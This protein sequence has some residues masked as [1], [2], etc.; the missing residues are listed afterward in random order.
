MCCQKITLQLTSIPAYWS[1]I[2]GCDCHTESWPSEQCIITTSAD[3]I[4]VNFS[5]IAGFPHLR[6]VF[7]KGIKESRKTTNLMSSAELG[8]EVS[9]GKLSSGSSS[10]PLSVSMS[11]A[12][13]LKEV[14]LRSSSTSTSEFSSH[15]ESPSCIENTPSSSGRKLRSVF[16][17]ESVVV[18]ALSVS[19]S[20]TSYSLYRLSSTACVTIATARLS[21]DV[22]LDALVYGNTVG[23]A[24]F[25]IL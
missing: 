3:P 20:K 21:E 1:P 10:L 19:I 4:V 11:E 17:E 2:F 7:S 5:I 13:C 24:S 23:I 12:S 14:S 22:R 8:L 9:T 25:F 18:H 6:Q 15:V 16:V